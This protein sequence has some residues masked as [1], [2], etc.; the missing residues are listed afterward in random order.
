LKKT[1]APPPVLTVT[2]WAERHRILSGKDSA[3]PGPYRVDRTHGAG[4]L[5]S[6]ASLLPWGLAQGSLALRSRRLPLQLALADA[7][8]LDPPLPLPPPD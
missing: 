3:E 6:A 8:A 7:L 1:T 5:A 2:Q 4:R